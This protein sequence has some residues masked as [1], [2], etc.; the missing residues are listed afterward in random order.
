MLVD[1]L[2]RNE[3]DDTVRFWA[4]R[5]VAVYWRSLMISSVIASPLVLIAPG[6][7]V[8]ATLLGIALTL[9]NHRMFRLEMT[10]THVR[11]KG[12]ALMPSL[13][14]RYAQIADVQAVDVQPAK[15]GKPPV[16]TLVLKLA[17]G[18]ALRLAGIIDPAEAAAAFKALKSQ[19]PRA[20]TREAWVR[21]A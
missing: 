16:G 9:I 4:E 20:G 3:R 1:S 17:V 12:A 10:P 6:A 11:L 18:H 2:R 21:T 13:Y 15:D 8:V 14:L 7:F 5:D 19:A